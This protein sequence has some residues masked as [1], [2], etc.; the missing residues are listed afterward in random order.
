MSE[1]ERQRANRRLTA[2]ILLVVVGMF[3][4]GYALVPLYDVFCRLTGLNGK[5][6]EAPARIEEAPLKVVE[7]RWVTVEFLSNPGNAA[8]WIFEPEIRK[9]K[10]HPGQA[11][12]NHYRVRNPSDRPMVARAVPSVAPGLAASHLHKTECFCF[13]RQL[14]A[15]GETR[16]LAL[17]F[18]LDPGIPSQVGIM[19]LAYTLYA[20]DAGEARVR[21]AGREGVGS[22]AG[23]TAAGDSQ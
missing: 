4:F 2:L 10:V 8:N 1:R 14:F 5:T 21:L 11:Y 17:R 23:A 9:L 7:D 6:A 20:E 13:H 15:A 19:S 22:D 3:A 16:R 18:M 12:L